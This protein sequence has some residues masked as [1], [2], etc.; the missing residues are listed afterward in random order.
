MNLTH[1]AGQNPCTQ[2]SAHWP[3]AAHAGHTSNVSK[4]FVGATT[5]VATPKKGWHLMTHSSRKSGL[6]SPYV[7]K[8]SNM[9]ALHPRLVSLLA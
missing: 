8:Q 7:F 6:S 4:T 3:L 1:D 9:Q 5:E 2:V